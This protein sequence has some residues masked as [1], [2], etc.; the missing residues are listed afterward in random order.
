MGYAEKSLIYHNVLCGNKWLDLGAGDDNNGK[1]IILLS[2]GDENNGKCTI[3]LPAGDGHSC[4]CNIFLSAGDDN[5][6]RCIIFAISF[7]IFQQFAI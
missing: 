1:C 6:G 5:N 4:K 2:A 3:Y 7:H